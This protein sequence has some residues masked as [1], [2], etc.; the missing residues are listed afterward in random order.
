VRPAAVRAL[1]GL[2]ELLRPDL[3]GLAQPAFP[4]PVLPG[5]DAT[6]GTAGAVPGTAATAIP[7]PFRTTPAPSAS[8]SPAQTSAAPSAEPAD[9]A[10]PPCAPTVRACVDL[11]A[12]RSW[13]LRDGHVTYGPVP[14]TH[15]R[16]GFHTPP[17]TFQVASK[18]RDHVSSIYDA[19]MP[20]SVFFNGGVAFHE[21]SLT[22]LSH[23]CIHLSSVAAEAYFATLSVGDVVQVV[24]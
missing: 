11:S 18:K 22:V 21:G 7:G 17:G 23:G 20:W 24:P 5:P 12:N 1:G 9:V 15:G 3:F 16:K 2:P 6:G 10:A 14:I 8:R 19:E 4:A 13:L